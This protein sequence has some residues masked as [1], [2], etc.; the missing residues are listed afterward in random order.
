M[1]RFICIVLACTMLASTACVIVHPQQVHVAA[2]PAPVYVDAPEPYDPHAA[3]H[4]HMKSVLS[5]QAKVA[6]QL[7]EG[8]WDDVLDEANDWTKYTRTLNTYANTSN[9]PKRF[10][11]CCAQLLV[12]IERLR[13]AAVRR[14]T[15]AC[16]RTLRTCDPLLNQLSRYAPVTAK[17]APVGAPHN[18]PQPTRSQ[19]P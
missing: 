3:Y 9:D 8:E 12:E 1:F 10:R 19:V 5:Q 15:G 13:S 7:E 4:Y 11:Q 16:E 18:S 17:P 6:K 14:D 2:S